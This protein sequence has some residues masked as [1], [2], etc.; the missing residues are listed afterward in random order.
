MSSQRPLWG[1]MIAKREG[2]ILM[3]K[4][5][6]LLSG[7][8]LAGLM[9]NPNRQGPRIIG[10]VTAKCSLKS[11][12][13]YP[14]DKASIPVNPVFLLEIRTEKIDEKFNLSDGEISLIHGEERLPLRVNSTQVIN[15]RVTVFLLSS[16]KAL[17]TETQ[18]G[19]EL[20]P[21]VLGLNPSLRNLSWTTGKEAIQKNPTW[22]KVPV[23]LAAKTEDYSYGQT[24]TVEIQVDVD[25]PILYYSGV[26]ASK[27]GEMSTIVIGRPDKGTAHFSWGGCD[28]SP[29]LPNGKY[30]L[31]ITPVDFAGNQGASQKVD[32]KIRDGSYLSCV[33]SCGCR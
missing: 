1:E 18:L 32:F 28:D 8:I 27:D 2:S 29:A 17:P 14:A 9:L 10:S 31:T 22:R 23:V 25:D 5:L 26:L 21:K 33:S 24:S 7:L 30:S 13:I 4:N 12:H 19:F 11:A 15:N 16:E 20:P 3:K 6:F